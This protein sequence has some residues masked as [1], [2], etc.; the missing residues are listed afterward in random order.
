MVQYILQV[1]K[2][3]VFVEGVE[4]EKHHMV[5][6]FFNINSLVLIR[7]TTLTSLLEV[8]TKIQ[9]KTNAVTL[10]LSQVQFQILF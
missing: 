10:D 5:T 4:Q 7:A 2:P 1:D 9:G 8:R 3:V 6:P